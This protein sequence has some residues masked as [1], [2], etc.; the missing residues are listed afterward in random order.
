MKPFNMTSEQLFNAIKRQIALDTK[1]KEED[2]PRGKDG[3]FA[4]NGGGSSSKITSA[5]NI[6]SS[7][8]SV[9]NGLITSLG[10]SHIKELFSDI[11][12]ELSEDEKKQLEINSKFLGDFVKGGG[13]KQHVGDV[14]YNDLDRMRDR[15]LLD[16][17]KNN[18]DKI[19]KHVG[20][21][22]LE[23]FGDMDTLSKANDYINEDW[24]TKAGNYVVFRSGDI[25]RDD[26]I[27]FAGNYGYAE[28]YSRIQR[29]DDEDISG[30]HNVR[31]YRVSIKK[32]FVCENIQDA[33]HK[34]FGKNAKHDD[35]EW[36]NENKQIVD[37][38]RS[39]GY[40]SWLIRN[41]LDPTAK[42]LNIVSEDLIR[43]MKNRK[44]IAKKIP[45]NIKIQWAESVRASEK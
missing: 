44:P 30:K 2:H 13:D 1:F 40:D 16:Y 6:R 25:K 36:E 19:A 41:P 8:C 14:L 45:D 18:K 42:E 33:L 4:K 27:F 17:Y 22:K 11:K 7:G 3:K 10:D 35:Y 38:L 12:D 39:K 24:G 21:E 29:D 15:V 32:P 5:K 20:K 9:T 43:T 34:L 23:E 26:V 37:I 28:D 31:A